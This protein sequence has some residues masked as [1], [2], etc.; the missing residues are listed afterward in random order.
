MYAWKIQH[1]TWHTWRLASRSVLEGE[2]DPETVIMG[3]AKV[4]GR[5]HIMKRPIP[6]PRCRAGFP[7]RAWRE[8]QAQV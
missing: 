3:E 8:L 7:E 5:K 2:T 6:N 1:Q 4:G